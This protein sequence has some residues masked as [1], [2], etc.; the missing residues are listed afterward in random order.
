MALA[1]CGAPGGGSARESNIAPA[2][3]TL[4]HKLGTQRRVNAVVVAP[5]L[6]S[7]LVR[8]HEAKT[9]PTSV[10]RERERMRAKQRYDSIDA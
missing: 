5:R 3:G 1:A 9:G 7:T 10:R 6:R 4:R 8:S 2:K